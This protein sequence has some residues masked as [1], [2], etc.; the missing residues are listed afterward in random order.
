M[1]CLNDDFKIIPP[2]TLTCY[3]EVTPPTHGLT[4]TTKDGTRVELPFDKE[5]NEDELFFPA[6]SSLEDVTTQMK[7]FG[8]SGFLSAATKEVHV[9]FVVYNP[10][11][12]VMGRLRLTIQ[13]SLAGYLSTKYATNTIPFDIYND[14]GTGSWQFHLEMLWLLLLLISMLR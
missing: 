14:T 13:V 9:Q 10:A 6:T 4:L 11:L 3:D 2:G 5:S 8:K 12:N 7:A 1:P